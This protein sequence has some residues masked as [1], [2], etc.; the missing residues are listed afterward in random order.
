MNSLDLRRILTE[1]NVV[2]GI[3]AGVFPRD[4]FE[5]F[6]VSPNGRR[7]FAAVFNTH[8]SSRDG[9]HW[10]AFVRLDDVGHYF[11]SYGRH[12]FSYPRL[13]R[14]LASTY[15]RI[16]WNDTRLQGLTTSVCGDYCVLFTLLLC[17]G[18]S[19]E[20]I[21]DRLKRHAT[22]EARDH[23]VRDT[24]INLYGTEALNSLRGDRP[25]LVGRDKV[26]VRAVVETIARA[27]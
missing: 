11:D 27:V 20:R 5:Q 19:F 23:S 8:D 3:F 15:R 10:I 17:R 7:N 12:P 6:V 4:V 25:D 21:V 9:E 13:A 24:I 14:A 1:D 16:R 26:H 2:G 22:S 18:W